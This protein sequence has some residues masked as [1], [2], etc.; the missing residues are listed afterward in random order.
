[1]KSLKT[2]TVLIALSL[3][4]CRGGMGL[5]GSGDGQD[6]QTD[7]NAVDRKYPRSQQDVWAAV[8]DAMESLDLRVESDKHDALGGTLIAR[9]ANNDRVVVMTRCLDEHSTHVAVSIGSGERNLAEI[10][11]SNIG[12]TLGIASA[13]SGFF[14][15]NQTERTYDAGVAKCVIAAERVAEEMNL[16]VT[17]RDIR[18]QYAEVVCRKSGS[19]PILIRMEPADRPAAD[20]NGAEPKRDGE[21]AGKTRVTFVTGTSRS[22]ENEALLQRVRSEFERL[23]R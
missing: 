12:R 13:K 21:G 15:G 7:A 20:R 3:S 10:V 16:D 22:E 1:M 9:R 2:C 5:F 23:L 19:G 14:G 4:A 17:H 18:D 8:T 6:G 11:H